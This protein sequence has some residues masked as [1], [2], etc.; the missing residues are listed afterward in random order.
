MG[1]ISN[2]NS[3][4]IFLGLYRFRR[5]SCKGD[6]KGRTQNSSLIL[7]ILTLRVVYDV[8]QPLF[9]RTE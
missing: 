8:A 9:I 6:G 4:Y 7:Q 2:I 3:K 1:K 5:T